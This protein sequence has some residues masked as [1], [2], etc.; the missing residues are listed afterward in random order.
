MGQELPAVEDIEF[1]ISTDRK[2]QHETL[3]FHNDKLQRTEQ[4]LTTVIQ[5]LTD[6]KNQAKLNIAQSEEYQVEL[7]E[8]KKKALKL[9]TLVK[10]YKKKFKH[11]YG[12][13][14]NLMNLNKKLEADNRKLAGILGGMRGEIVQNARDY[15]ERLEQEK[16]NF[17]SQIATLTRSAMD[18]ELE[19][20]AKI[21]KLE[22]ELN[23]KTE[24]LFEEQQKRIKEKEELR[25]KLQSLLD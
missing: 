9:G 23:D 25:Q 18:K 17:K 22:S 20:N 10:L 12:V 24:L 13:G 14:R 7:H 21:N 6:I 4:L 19:L 2:Q 5:N 16:R 1:S 3:S 8:L 11:Y 15:T